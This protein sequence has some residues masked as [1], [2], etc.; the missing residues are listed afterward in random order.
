MKV[1]HIRHKPQQTKGPAARKQ[2]R[3]NRGLLRNAIFRLLE[4]KQRLLVA[5]G[6]SLQ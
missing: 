3:Q 1:R 2:K 4:K 5:L 6:V